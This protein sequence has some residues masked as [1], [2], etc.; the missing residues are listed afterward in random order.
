LVMNIFYAD[1]NVAFSDLDAMAIGSVVPEVS[2]EFD[3]YWNNRHSFPVATLVAGVANK[4]VPGDALDN[5]RNQ[6]DKFD[7]QPQTM[8][9]RDAV[10]HSA[11]ANALRDKTA[12][13]SFSEAKIIHDS[14]EKMTKVNEDWKDELL[15]SQLPP[16][17][18]QAK[19]E[20][21]LVSPYFVPGQR[22]LMQYAS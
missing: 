4:A 1:K 17:I 16:Y 2:A 20:F 11:L 5:L 15:M 6:L 21:I 14:A 18:L 9:Y 12:K 7:Q 8:V 13:F 3:Q 10:N 19:K 22:V